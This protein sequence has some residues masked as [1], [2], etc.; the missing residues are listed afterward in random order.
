MR[1][2]CRDCEDIVIMELDVERCVTHF[3]CHRYIDWQEEVKLM[4]EDDPQAE[5]GLDYMIDDREV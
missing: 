5:R 2:P 1:N 3:L 4:Q